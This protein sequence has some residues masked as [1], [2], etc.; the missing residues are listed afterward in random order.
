MAECGFLVH[1]R[2]AALHARPDG[3]DTMR[4]KDLEKPHEFEAG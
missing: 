2:G 3:C 4:L 1:W